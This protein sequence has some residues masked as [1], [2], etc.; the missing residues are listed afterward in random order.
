LAKSLE[1]N[2]IIYLIKKNYFGGIITS[3]FIGWRRC[4][5]VHGPKNATN[6]FNYEKQSN[7]NVEEQLF[8]ISG[9]LTH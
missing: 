8:L 2:S 4:R 3:L 6:R 5:C 1:I 9:R 7:G